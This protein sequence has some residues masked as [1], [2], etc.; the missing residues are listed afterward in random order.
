MK[1]SLLSLT[2]AAASGV[3]AAPSNQPGELV[4]RGSCPRR[5]DCRCTAVFAQGANPVTY[6]STVE[7]VI[8]GQDS[9]LTTSD[10][11]GS[12]GN[13]KASL[14]RVTVDRVC[15]SC[16]AWKSTTDKCGYY[17]RNSFNC[18]PA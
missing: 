15:G 1:F 5:V 6:G 3:L 13:G 7:A 16:A 2:L 10:W 17:G 12:D 8:S 11:R 4:A 9:G 14:C 18:S